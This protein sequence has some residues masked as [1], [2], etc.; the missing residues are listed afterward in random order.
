MLF[1]YE[2]NPPFKKG[3][4]GGIFIKAWKSLSAKG[5]LEGQHSLSQKH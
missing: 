3:G 5:R 1:A 2:N 4:A